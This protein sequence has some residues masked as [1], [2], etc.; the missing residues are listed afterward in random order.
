[1]KQLAPICRALLVQPWEIICF[2]SEDG[3]G[4][5][6]LLKLLE[7][8]TAPEPEAAQAHTMEQPT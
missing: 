7:A 5:E 8:V 3:T 6:E 4:R 2:S 1:M